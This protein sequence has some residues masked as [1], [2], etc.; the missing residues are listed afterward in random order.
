MVWVE[1]PMHIKVCT[2]IHTVLCIQRT[3]LND[4]M[5]EKGSTGNTTIKDIIVLYRSTRQKRVAGEITSSGLM[6]LYFP[7][8]PICS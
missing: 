1:V 5:P 8:Q 4:D 3:I 2:C 6:V 7:S